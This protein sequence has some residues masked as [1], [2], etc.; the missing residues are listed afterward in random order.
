M[1]NAPERVEVTKKTIQVP[2]VMKK[3]RTSTTKKDNA[4]SKCSRKEKT[5][6]LQKI[7]TMSE[8]KVDRH[9]VDIIFHNLALK[10]AI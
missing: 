6:P 3:G 8:P 5:I 1:V 7:V 4:P 2:S 9:I 10:H